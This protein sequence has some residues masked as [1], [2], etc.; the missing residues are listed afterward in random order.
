MTCPEGHSNPDDRELC[1][2]CGALL[3]EAEPWTSAWYRTKWAIVGASVLALPATEHPQCLA[4]V[5]VE[6]ILSCLSPRGRPVDRAHAEAVGKV[7]EEAAVLVVGV[8][9]HLQNGARHRPRP[10]TIY[11]PPSTISLP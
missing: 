2:E 11:D 10:T 1:E 9:A 4:P 8:R 5:G 6:P 3:G 7:G